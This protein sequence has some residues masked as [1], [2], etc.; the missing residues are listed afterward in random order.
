MNHS[1]NP[2]CNIDTKNLH[3]IAAR[4]IKVGEELTF[5][6]P[7]TE[8]IMDKPFECKCG[9]NKCIKNVE[10]ASKLSIDDLAGYFI[11]IHILDSIY[12]EIQTI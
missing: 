2:T 4:D 12:N 7:S 9:H 3:I 6:Y 1:C 5:F 8:W 11:N 10:G